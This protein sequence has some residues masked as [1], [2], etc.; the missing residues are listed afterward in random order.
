V[1]TRKVRVDAVALTD[2]FEFPDNALNS[3]VGRHDGNVCVVGLRV[4][5]VPRVP[6]LQYRRV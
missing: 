5:R 3:A 1:G 6:T 2:A 4:P